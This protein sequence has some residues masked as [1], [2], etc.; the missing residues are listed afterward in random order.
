MGSALLQN[1]GPSHASRFVV[2]RDAEGHWI[3]SDEKGLV[4]GMFAD[5]ASAVR[6][7]MLE[8]DHVPGAV[9]CA[10]D[11][12]TINLV[13]LLGAAANIEAGSPARRR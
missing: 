4:G 12:V 13:P 2:G 8:S 1:Q 9:F 6:F 7:A 11:V 3:V 10:P 5:R